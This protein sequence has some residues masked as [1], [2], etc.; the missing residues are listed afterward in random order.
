[1]KLYDHGRNIVGPGL[2]AGEMVQAGNCERKF[3][4]IGWEVADG[5]PGECMPQGDSA[6][7]RTGRFFSKHR[8]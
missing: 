2:Q 3:Q 6:I 7:D 1:M 8:G 4:R 5:L